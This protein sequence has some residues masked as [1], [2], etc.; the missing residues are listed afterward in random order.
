MPSTLT[1][2]PP[3]LP[4]PLALLLRGYRERAEVELLNANIDIGCPLAVS[5]RIPTTPARSLC[6]ALRSTSRS[7]RIPLTRARPKV[8]EHRP[9]G[10]VDPIS[11]P[12]LALFACVSCWESLLLPVTSIARAAFRALRRR[13]V[14]IHRLHHQ[15]HVW[16]RPL[17]TCSHLCLPCI[18]LS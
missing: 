6:P 14:G 11:N 8:P 4:P 5:D 13:K 16:W 18:S 9:R 7:P 2:R 3:M 17:L 10:R 15:D 12:T 1:S